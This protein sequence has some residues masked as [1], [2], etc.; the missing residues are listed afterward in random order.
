MTGTPRPSSMLCCTLPLVDREYFRASEI[1]YRDIAL[2]GALIGFRSAGP[3]ARP[4]R[5]WRP[6]S[7]WLDRRRSSGLRG[8]G[9]SVPG[10]FGARAEAP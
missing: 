3:H 6:S 9:E 2:Q 10:L 4:C 1:S 5:H 8:R 7:G